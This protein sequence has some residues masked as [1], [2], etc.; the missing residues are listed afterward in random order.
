MPETS[1]PSHR[2]IRPPQST[3]PVRALRVHVTQLAGALIVPV[4]IDR[5]TLM[6]QVQH[7]STTCDLL[8]DALEVLG[9]N[10]MR[11]W[12]TAS[13]I[14]TPLETIVE[15]PW[16]CLGDLMWVRATPEQVPPQIR[17]R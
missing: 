6:V 1:S 10:V 7:G 14:T 4:Y 11:M 3:P 2:I 12:F 17:V 15:D 9:P 13:G 8:H 5:H 16:G